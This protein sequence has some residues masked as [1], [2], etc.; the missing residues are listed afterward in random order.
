MLLAKTTLSSV[1]SEL[2]HWPVFMDIP[3]DA[4]PLAEGASD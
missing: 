1:T 2:Y 3:Y 4:P